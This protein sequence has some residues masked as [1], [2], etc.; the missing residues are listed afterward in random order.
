ME[1]SAKCTICSNK[2]F[3]TRDCDISDVHLKVKHIKNEQQKKSQKKNQNK[4]R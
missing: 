4:P 3:S 2:R 1:F